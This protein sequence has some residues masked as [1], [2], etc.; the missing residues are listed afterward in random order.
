MPR[1]EI[2]AADGPTQAHLALPA[3]AN[4]P[5]PGVLLFVDAFGLRPRIVDMA[6]RIAAWGYVVLA[7]NTFYRTGTDADL[8]PAEDLREPGARRRFFARIDSRM[9]DLTT[10]RS[11]ADTGCYLAALRARPEV[12]AG[13]MGVVGY[14]MGARLATR[15]AGAYPDD[16]AAVGGFHGGRLVTDAP[17]SPHRWIGG[18]RAGFAYC[19]ADKDSSMTRRDARALGET[20]TEAGVPFENEVYPGAAHGYTM[21]DTSAFHEAACEHHFDMLERLF[22]RQLPR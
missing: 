21:S 20:L 16:V 12:A 2:P 10:E 18:S 5:A 4:T 11:L 7:P 19:H 6:E 22:A 15:A 8:A 9:T 14:C 1:L 17:D 3:D 13:P